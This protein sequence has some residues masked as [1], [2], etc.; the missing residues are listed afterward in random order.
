MASRTV[1]GDVPVGV[2]WVL[3]FTL[4]LVTGFVAWLVSGEV[5]VGLILFVATGTALGFT[6]E[7]SL[8]TRQLTPHEQRLVRLALVVGLVVGAALLGYVLLFA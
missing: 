2:G 5:T 7:Q 8:A 6:V 1:S 3:G 4:G